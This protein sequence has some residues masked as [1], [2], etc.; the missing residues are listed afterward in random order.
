MAAFLF[1]LNENVIEA[2]DVALQAGVDNNTAEID[3]NKADIDA[4]TA[5]IDTNTAD[6]DALQTANKGDPGEIVMS[7][8][9]TCLEPLASTAVTV[10]CTFGT[11]VTGSDGFLQTAITGPV[12]MG[13]SFHHRRH[14]PQPG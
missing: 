7:H 12:S 8:D 10:S 13:G 14:K 11:T 6:I 5:D 9:S 4:N 3:A 2:A 1:R